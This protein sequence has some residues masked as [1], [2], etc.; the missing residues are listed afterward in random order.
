LC[1][2]VSWCLCGHFFYFLPENG[3]ILLQGNLF[4]CLLN[5][6]TGSASS[7]PFLHSPRSVGG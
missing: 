4:E 1:F 5:Q 3:K 2:L 6:G 7:L